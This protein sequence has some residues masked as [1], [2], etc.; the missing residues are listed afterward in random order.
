VNILRYTIFFIAKKSTFSSLIHEMNRW[1][2]KNNYILNLDGSGSAQAYSRDVKYN[3][4]DLWFK[5]DN[6]LLPNAIL[7]YPN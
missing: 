2:I 5:G 6:R 1:G 4:H 3:Y 7:L